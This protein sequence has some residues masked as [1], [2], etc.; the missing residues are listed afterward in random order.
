MHLDDFLE[1]EYGKW[2]QL[3]IIV[4]SSYGVGQAPL[5]ARKFREFCDEILKRHRD[6]NGEGENDDTKVI[7]T[8]RGVYFAL[9]G[10]GDSP[11]QY[12]L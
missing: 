9:L 7:P 12:V 4:C 5:G 3:I 6:G 10:L 1:L 8:L 2:T 11:L